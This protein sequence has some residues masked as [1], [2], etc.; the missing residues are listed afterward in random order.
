MSHTVWARIALIVDAKGPEMVSPEGIEL[1]TL[2]LEKIRHGTNDGD[3]E[4]H[5]QRKSG[6]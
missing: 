5:K 6:V 3:A 4:F 1:A 2:E